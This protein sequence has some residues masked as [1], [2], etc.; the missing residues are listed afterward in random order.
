MLSYSL[1]KGCITKTFPNKVENFFEKI[2]KNE[3]NLFY[4]SLFIRITPLV[5]NMLVNVASPIAG[6]PLKLFIMTTFIGLM[7][8]NFI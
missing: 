3:N 4:Y 8:I 6:I 5:P 2:K 7:P 1:L